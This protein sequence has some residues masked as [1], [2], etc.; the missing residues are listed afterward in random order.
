MSKEIRKHGDSE[1]LET[2]LTRLERSNK[3]WRLAALGIVGAWAL[4]TSCSRSDSGG[5]T[6]LAAEQP[7]ENGEV[8]RKLRVNEIELVN[9][10]GATVGRINQGGEP[11][12]SL[13]F[14]DENAAVKSTFRLR[15]KEGFPAM[16][17]FAQKDSIQFLLNTLVLSDDTH[18]LSLSPAGLTLRGSES[19]AGR[20]FQR[21]FGKGAESFKHRE[22]LATAMRETEAVDIS[23]GDGGGGMITLRNTFGKSVVEVEANK[24]NEGAV[25]VNDVNGKAQNALTPR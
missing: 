23:I 13:A 6:A 19:V 14:P 15:L 24:A 11:S 12:L 1:D 20:K 18:T 22:E 2:R 9:L 16:D 25:Y 7:A 21:V 8:V 4:T 3:A 17:F 10:K 5:Q